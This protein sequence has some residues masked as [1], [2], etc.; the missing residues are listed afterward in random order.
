[1]ILNNLPSY[2]LVSSKN[3]FHLPET[4]EKP[5]GLRLTIHRIKIYPLFIGLKS[6]D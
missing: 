6:E 3:M 1:M 2:S 5:W 4:Q